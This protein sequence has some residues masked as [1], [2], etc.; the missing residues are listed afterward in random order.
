MGSSREI[1]G[2][3]ARESTQFVDMDKLEVYSKQ[4]LELLEK[5]KQRIDSELKDYSPATLAAGGLALGYVL[6]KVV[7][8]ITWAPKAAKKSYSESP[9]RFRHFSSFSRFLVATGEVHN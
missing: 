7:S 6:T 9:S 2:S 5:A 1:C 4:A 3:R 8:S